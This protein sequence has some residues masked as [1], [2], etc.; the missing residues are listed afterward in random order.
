MSQHIISRSQN[1]RACGAISL[2]LNSIFRKKN[3]KRKSL[4]RRPSLYWI[5]VPSIFTHHKK[6][7]FDRWHDAKFVAI[8]I[9][10][11]I[12]QPVCF[13]S[14]HASDNASSPS[15]SPNRGFENLLS[16]AEHRPASRWL[17]MRLNSRFAGMTIQPLNQDF[18]LSEAPTAPASRRSPPS[19]QMSPVIRT[20]LS[21]PEQNI[22]IA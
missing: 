7:P 13:A 4:L 1:P 12:R 2:L 11:S 5:S 14:L 3:A 6:N 9:F 15:R 8:C 21:P 19:G 17:V 10:V 20:A 18:A 22:G 16:C